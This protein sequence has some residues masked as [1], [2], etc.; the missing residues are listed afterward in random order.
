MC[1]VGS[2]LSRGESYSSG[3]K[4]IF[5]IPRFCFVENYDN[6]L[7]GFQLEIHPQKCRGSSFLGAGRVKAIRIKLFTSLIFQK[8]RCI[9]YLSIEVSIANA[10]WNRLF[11]SSLLENL[12]QANNQVIISSFF[13][14]PW[15]DQFIRFDVCNPHFATNIF[16]ANVLF[17]VTINTR[18]RAHTK[19][20]DI[21]TSSFH[22]WVIAHPTYY[23]FRIWYILY[24]EIARHPGMLF[25]PGLLSGAC[26]GKQSKPPARLK[27]VRQGNR[28]IFAGKHRSMTIVHS[29]FTNMGLRKQD[30]GEGIKT[31]YIHPI[32]RSWIIGN[33]FRKDSE[34]ETPSQ[35]N[36]ALPSAFR[37]WLRLCRGRHSFGEAA[38]GWKICVG[39][40][41]AILGASESTKECPHFRQVV[42]R[43]ECPFRPSQRISHNSHDHHR[44]SRHL[45]FRWQTTQ[46]LLILAWLLCRWAR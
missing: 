41:V 29:F 18:S 43:D 20:I 25:Q 31:C 1:T 5:I 22:Y 39:S 36:N 34:V 7:P 8:T 38:G 19:L 40:I 17:G 3:G 6:L 46:R 30:E 32:P 4:F 45:A 11:I 27:G 28:Q 2:I 10:W 16:L 21:V 24:L 37:F 13:N 35:T 9:I 42:K 15:E 14:I 44:F 12:V 23:I 26:H 33:I